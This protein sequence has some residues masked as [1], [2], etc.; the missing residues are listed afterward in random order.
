M[1]N[2]LG[3]KAYRTLILNE[4]NGAALQKYDA[5]EQLLC[6]L[7]NPHMRENGFL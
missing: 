5:C 2:D 4:L 3:L 7:N 6:F 1:K